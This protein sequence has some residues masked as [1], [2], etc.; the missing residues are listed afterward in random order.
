MEEKMRAEELSSE[1]LEQISGG[2]GSMSSLQTGIRC[3]RCG[4]KV[5]E[6]R[7]GN[8]TIQR[9]SCGW[10]QKMVLTVVR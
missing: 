5:T 9:C 6:E 7:S 1:K 2:S 8:A 4:N 10:Q 3:P